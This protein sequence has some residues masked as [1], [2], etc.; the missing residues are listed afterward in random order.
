[1]GLDKIKYPKSSHLSTYENIGLENDFSVMNIMQNNE[2]R[3]K[4]EKP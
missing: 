3:P 4:G 2:E 1:V